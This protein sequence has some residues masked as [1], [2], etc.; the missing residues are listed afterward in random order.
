M[1]LK[2]GKFCLGNSRE[3]WWIN[4][5]YVNNIS[6]SMAKVNQWPSIYNELWWTMAFDI[7][8]NHITHVFSTSENTEKRFRYYSSCY[9]GV[10]KIP[11]LKECPRDPLKNTVCLHFFSKHLFPA[12]KF[13][14]SNWWLMVIN[15]GSWWLMI[16][17]LIGGF[18]LPLW[19]MMEWVRQ[20]GWFFIPNCFWKVM[21]SIPWF[22]SPPTRYYNLTLR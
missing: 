7:L 6:N 4:V 22:Q 1:H 2:N 15:Y 19:K 10:S 18:F 20:L 3:K 5:N 13:L 16:N 14:L 12:I 17:Y 9:F 11:Q 8:K 21:K